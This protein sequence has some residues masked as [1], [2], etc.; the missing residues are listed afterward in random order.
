VAVTANVVEIIVKARDDTGAGMA[1][2]KAS[3]EEG[4]AGADELAAAT[5]RAAAA[6]EEFR[7]A[8]AE[9]AGAAAQLEG[10][11][12]SGTASA[13]E[14]AGAQDRLTAATLSSMDAQI[15]LAAA[16]RD[17]A[18]AQ[19]LAGDAAEESAA[20]ADTSGGLLAS[21]GGKMKMALLGVAVGAGIAVKAASDFQDQTTHLVTDAGELPGKL[22]MVQQGILAVSAATGTSASAIT[23]AMYHI[24]SGGLHAKAGLAVLKVAAEGAKVGGAELDVV[25]KT[26]VGTLNSYYGASLNAGNATKLSTAMMNQLIATVGAGDMRMQDLA[27]SLGNVTP[28][29]AAA[30]IS[31]AEVGGAMATMTSQNMSAQQAAQ[32]LRH[33][34]LSM[35]NPNATQ[36]KELKAIGLSA[37]EVQQSLGS[38]GLAATLQMV[39]AAA[40]KSHGTLGQTYVQALAKAMGGTTGLNTALMLTGPN[41][42][43]FEKNA[44][45]VAVAAK[46]G[47][48]SVDN[49]GK[50]QGTFKFKMDQAKASI[51]DMGISLGAALLPAVTAIL[52]PIAHFLS[53]IAANKAASIALAAVIGGVLAG[54]IGAKAASAMKDLSGG[55][56][57]AGEGMSWLVGK[58]VAMTAAQEGQTAAT[59]AGTVAQEEMDAAEDANPIG[60]IILAIVALVVAIYELVKHWRTVWKFIKEA[61]LEA[62]HFLD[63]DVL[64]PIEHAFARVIDWIKSHWQLLVAILTGPLGI[65]V[66]LITHYW[67]DIQH[68]A[69]DAF[70]M[71]TRAISVAYDWVKAHWPLLLAILTGP[72]GLAVLYIVDHWKQITNGA[73][74]MFGD[75]VS[76]FQKLPGKILSVLGDLGSLLFNAGKS[77]IQGLINGV[78]SMVGGLGNAMGGIASTIKS[79]LPF[80]PAKKGPLSGAGAPRNSGLSI[81]RQIAEGITAGTPVA[82]GAMMGLAQRLA[83]PVVPGRAGAYGA[84]AAGGIPEL[85]ITYERGGEDMF[86]RWLR[87]YIR[88]HGGN[89]QLV[90]GQGAA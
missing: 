19:G 62:W 8:Q 20:K 50:I 88:I 29:A 71:V 56:K 45:T 43:V 5:Q 38:K 68:G 87:Q 82:H 41:M 83:G 24:E 73:S 58:I 80:S 21:A 69:E 46:K 7:A 63:N 72:I 16:D 78:E 64:H 37:K 6:E 86:I 35:E 85:K 25:S 26:L 51:Q 48:S 55:I 10:L 36:A 12:Q 44:K 40:A 33:T 4:A 14:L 1:A 57:A 22:G 28:V 79:Y 70:K 66:Y 49:W 9:A 89:V 52:G 2:A 47:G 18:A 34:L 23:D 30:K 81:A 75:V 84:A 32:D 11:Q 65:A 61:A 39:A 27:A 42:T 13:D 59:E 54:A 90:L 31:F 67:S 53:L 60:L 77:V 76:F 3:A 74:K 15:R 17:V